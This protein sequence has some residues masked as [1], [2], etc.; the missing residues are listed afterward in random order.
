M[1]DSESKPQNGELYR[2]MAEYAQRDLSFLPRWLMAGYGLYDER[3]WAANIIEG[4][5]S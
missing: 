4:L 3:D 1:S 5:E 2:K